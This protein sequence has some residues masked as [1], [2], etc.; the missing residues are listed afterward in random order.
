MIRR[1]GM[2][3]G[4]GWPNVIRRRGMRRGWG[5][6]NVIR[7]RGH[8]KIKGRKQI[9]V[10]VNAKVIDRKLLTIQLDVNSRDS[11]LW[12]KLKLESEVGLSTH[13]MIISNTKD[14]EMSDEKSL[15]MCKVAM[16]TFIIIKRK[17]WY[18]CPLHYSLQPACVLEL[19][20]ELYNMVSCPCSPRSKSLSLNIE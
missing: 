8:Q 13:K 20:T 17:S 5:W 4:W 6:P 18:Y 10:Y 15:A 2:R 11:I 12:V 7:R 3:R 19:E 1:R 14:K 16:G 9:R